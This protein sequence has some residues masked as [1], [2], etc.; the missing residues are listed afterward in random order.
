MNKKTALPIACILTL[1][2]IL[3]AGVA[4]SNEACS[5]PF[6]ATLLAGAPE[7]LFLAPFGR[8]V[9]KSTCIPSGGAEY[10]C[11]PEPVGG[12]GSL[13]GQ[14]CTSSIPTC[15]QQEVLRS[16]VPDELAPVPCN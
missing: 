15:S 11:V 9:C 16:C 1:L 2:S 3:P 13:N 14:S 8:C 5:K 4:L 12:C 6:S 7:P 10:Q